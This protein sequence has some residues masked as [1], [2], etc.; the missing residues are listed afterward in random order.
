MLPPDDSSAEK[1]VDVC[2]DSLQGRSV[3]SHGGYIESLGY[4]QPY[5]PDTRCQ[6]HLVTDDPRAE[7]ILTVLDMQLAPGDV[8]CRVSSSL[9]FIRAFIDCCSHLFKGVAGTFVRECVLYEHV[10]I[11]GVLFCRKLN[12]HICHMFMCNVLM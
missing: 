7:V 12:K 5:P 8:G 6:C 3:V 9:D 4:P 11:H 2:G 10:H 1:I